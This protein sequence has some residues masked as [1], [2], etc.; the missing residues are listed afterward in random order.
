[1]IT[2]IFLKE[3]RAKLLGVDDIEKLKITSVNR[4]KLINHLDNI[5][6]S[7]IKLGEYDNTLRTSESFGKNIIPELNEKNTGLLYFTEHLSEKP[8][9]LQLRLK[10]LIEQNIAKKFHYV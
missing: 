7:R 5:G 8:I 6:L 10:Y 9:N 4:T 1:M 2:G 3:N